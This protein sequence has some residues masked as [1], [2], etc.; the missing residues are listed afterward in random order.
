MGVEC[1]ASH[2]SVTNSVLSEVQRRGV[3]RDALLAALNDLG[4]RELPRATRTLLQAL[5]RARIDT[6]VR[7][8]AHT[9][10][11]VYYALRRH[12]QHK[13]T[14]AIASLEPCQAQL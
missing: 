8:H 4:A 7:T 12:A 6:K 3:S 1:P 9:R 11:I 5:H 13:I 10:G 2:V 14:T